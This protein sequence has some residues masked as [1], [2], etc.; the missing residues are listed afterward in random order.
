MNLKNPRAIRT[1]ALESLATQPNHHKVP[2]VYAGIFSLLSLAV[3]VVNHIISLKIDNMTGLANMGSRAIFSTIS[4]VLSMVPTIFIIGWEMGYLTCVLRYARRRYVEPLDL[5]NGFSRFWPILRAKILMGLVYVG[6]AIGCMYLSVFIFMSL[7][8]SN[9]FYELMI[10]LMDSVTVMS[11]AITIDEATLAAASA[12]M[13]PAFVIFG[14]V[15]LVASLPVFYGFR[16]VHFCICDNGHRGALAAMK[17]SRTMM[18]GHKRELFK[19]DLSFWWFFLLEGLVSVLCYLDFLL[20]MAGIT[21]PLPEAV[22][23]YGFYVLS[24]AGQVLLYWAFLNR[25]T[26]SRA[27]F[28][29]AIRPQ[30]SASQGVALGNIF[31]LAKD[32]EE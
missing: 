30:E 25:V 1:A 16:M 31:E 8:I 7:P 26:V 2:L 9:A 23:Y 15:F 13:W 5:K 19:L 32:Y 17:A 6:L 28:Y 14:V 29:D 4:S 11:T 20:P 18:K 10:P 22:S 27:I 3:V 24:L 21:L 12:A